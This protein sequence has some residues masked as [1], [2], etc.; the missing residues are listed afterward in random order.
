LARRDRSVT[1][2]VA[3][4]PTEVVIIIKPPASGETGGSAATLSPVVGGE[5]GIDDKTIGKK[6]ITSSLFPY[7][8]IER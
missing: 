7:T 8:W 1:L 5:M 6:P 3:G 2:A 4:I